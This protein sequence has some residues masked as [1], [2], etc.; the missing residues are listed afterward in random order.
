[1]SEMGWAAFSMNFHDLP[2]FEKLSQKPRKLLDAMLRDSIQA[3][4]ASSCGRLFDAV[5]AALDLCFE[6]QG[7]E[8]E[9]A[10]R[11][12][13]VACK[14][15]LANGDPALDYPFTIPNLK[16]SR[17]PYIEPLAVW[18]AILG[19]LTLAT[20]AA[21][22]SARFHRGLARAVAAMAVKLAQRDSQDGPRFDTVAL[23]GGC[24]NNRILLE[25][26]TA[27]LEDCGF[28]V[29]T[30]VRS[31]AGD[32]GLALGQAAIAAA[33]AGNKKRQPGKH[34]EGQCASESPAAS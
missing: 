8:G 24:F 17:L 11:L 19:D 32:G 28:H 4:K 23:S 10:A 25:H 7:Y 26:V 29:L 20:P 3:P 6:S 9:A 12:E 31:P 27:R 16:G 2:L 18:N 5:S 13:A 21:V 14:Q 1:M 34:G 30:H 15:T 22:I 33:L